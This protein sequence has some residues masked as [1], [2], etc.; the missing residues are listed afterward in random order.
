MMDVKA[1]EFFRMRGSCGGI[2]I[3]VSCPMVFLYPGFSCARCRGESQKGRKVP[4]KDPAD[5]FGAVSAS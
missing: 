5:E 1:G 2:W 4:I 3:R